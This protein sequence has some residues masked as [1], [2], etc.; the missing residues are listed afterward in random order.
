MLT[1]MIR[2]IMMMITND[3]AADTH[4][5]DDNVEEDKVVRN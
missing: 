2:V 4:D 3:N 5:L 1:V